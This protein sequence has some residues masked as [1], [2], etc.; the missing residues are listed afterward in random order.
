MDSVT[1]QAGERTVEA[2]PLGRASTAQRASRVW[3]A[4]LEGLDEATEV[5]VRASAALRG[6]L[7]DWTGVPTPAEPQPHFGSALAAAQRP[8][9]EELLELEPECKYAWRAAA[10]AREPDPGE[11]CAP[12]WAK[13]RELDP[14]RAGFYDHQAR[15]QAQRRRLA[16]PSAEG[17]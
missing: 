9:L 16:V 8:L 4:T 3:R 2:E 6:R 14:L 5:V 13:L 17:V 11:D 10:R 7:F 15:R 12:V 1:V